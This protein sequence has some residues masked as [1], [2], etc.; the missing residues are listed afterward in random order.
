[1]GELP[2]LSK[3]LREAR[4]AAGISQEQLGILAGIDEFSASAR[5]NQYERGRH[6]PNLQLMGRIAKVL[7]LPVAYFYADEDQLATLLATYG[8]L[9]SKQRKRLMEVHSN[10]GL[11]LSN[12]F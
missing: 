11:S 8:R 9:S 5:M 3:R 1:M 7:S 12:R 6:S 4:A 10:R 2:V